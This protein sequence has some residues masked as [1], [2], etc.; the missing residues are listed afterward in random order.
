M[1]FALDKSKMTSF[2]TAFSRVSGSH[3]HHRAAGNI[4]NTRA[5]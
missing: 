5:N 4:C 1:T 2:L 3:M